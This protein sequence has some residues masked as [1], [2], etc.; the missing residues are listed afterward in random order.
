MEKGI[1]NPDIVE[2][3]V[4]AL[5]RGDPDIGTFW[6]PF[7]P[8]DGSEDPLGNDASKTPPN[9]NFCARLRGGR[10]S[11]SASFVLVLSPVRSEKY[12]PASIGVV[13]GALGT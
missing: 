1:A 3:A 2:N 11:L 7:A 13:L 4:F 10:F 12:T 6:L 5:L 9:T 8:L